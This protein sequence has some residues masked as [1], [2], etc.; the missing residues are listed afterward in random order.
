MN[1]L[2][3]ALSPCLLLLQTGRVQ[4]HG[5]IDQNAELFELLPCALAKGVL[6][7]G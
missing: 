3:F 6:L 1:S 5:K 4:A 2:V 7:S